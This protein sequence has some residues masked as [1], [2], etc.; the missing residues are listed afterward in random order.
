M[1]VVILAVVVTGAMLGM[2]VVRFIRL[3]HQ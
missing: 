3:F 2:A 1:A